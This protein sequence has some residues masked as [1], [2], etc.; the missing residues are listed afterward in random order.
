MGVL[1]NILKKNRKNCI[2]DYSPQ[3]IFSD[4]P[5]LIIVFFRIFA[6]INKMG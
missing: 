3:N 1:P 4:K 2:N 5:S 6:S